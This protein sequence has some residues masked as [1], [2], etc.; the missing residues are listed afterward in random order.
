MQYNT[1]NNS[2]ITLG[3]IDASTQGRH[4]KS[5]F[6]QP[7]LAGYPGQY[8]NALIRK[9]TL[10]KFIDTLRNKPVI[11][12]HKEE[13]TE[14]DKVGEVFNVWF[15]PE[16]GWYWCDGIIYDKEAQKLIN[17]G[18]SVSCSYNYTQSAE[19]GT[20]NNIPYDIEFLDGEFEHLAIVE[21]PRY[22]RANIVFNAKIANTFEGHA[23]R[24]GQVGGSLPKGINLNYKQELKQI[25]EKAKNLPNERQKL[26]IGKVSQKLANKAKEHGKEKTEFPRGQIPIE[27]EDFEKIPDIIYSYDEIEFT[28][29][30][31]I[32][33]ET[34]TYKKKMP[35][36]TIFYVEEIRNGQKTLT[37]NTMYKHKNTGNPRTSVE[38]DNPPSNASIYIVPQI[39]TNQTPNV[40]EYKGII[41]N[42]IAKAITEKIIKKYKQK[43]I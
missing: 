32:G 27:D 37:I 18:W 14:K 43:E 24:K 1:I 34:I 3:D 30:N 23:G 21:N 39:N 15:N 12:N 2:I 33:L 31:K 26:V 16:D 42:A 35:D 40:K 4:F 22:E 6:I 28:G 25:I 20:E 7:G 41:T 13:I 17:N 5:R 8:G 29:K 10:D 38:N 9:E 11:I 36:N 19:G